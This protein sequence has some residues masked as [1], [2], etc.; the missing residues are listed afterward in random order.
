MHQGSRAL[1]TDLYELTMVQA[2]WR[3]GLTD[4][5]VFDLFVR[6]LSPR[7]NFLLA[8][9][10]DDV[11][12][13]LETLRFAPDELE[14]L[15][16]Q[17]Q[18]SRD[19]VEWLADFRFTGRVRAVREG[20]VI[21]A[22]EPILE[23]AAPLAEAQL[24]ETFLLNQINLQTTLASK[25]ARVALAARGRRV[26]DFG[27]RRMQGTDAALRGARAFYIGGIASTS[28]VQAGQ[29]YGIPI[30]G[31]MAH[32]YIQVHD[33]EDAAYRAF[34]ALYPSGVML[35][36]T[37]DTLE[38]VQ[39]VIELA[40]ELGDAFRPRGVRLDSGDLLEL[41]R[42]AREMLDSA[43]LQEIEVYASGD[44]DEDRIA[45]LV[46][47]GAPIDSFGVGSGLGAS[48]DA[49]YVDV[50]YKL[51]EYAGRARVKLSPG[52]SLLPGRKQIF[53]EEENGCFVRDVVGAEDEERGGSPLLEW[54]MR[55][56]RRFAAAQ[57]TLEEIRD[58]AGKQIASLPDRLR[59]LAPADPPYRVEAS[60]RLQA[61]QRESAES[62]RAAH[63][64][65]SAPALAGEVAR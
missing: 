40:R 27:M 63:A 55:D 49:P 13:Y 47:R 3:E 16:A 51:T 20:T 2:Y 28:N 39:R 31:T 18:F 56:G 36:D 61:L 21:F 58:Y 50:V 38:G 33:S 29:V 9:G 8:C 52:K 12:S 1:F 54:V 60:A 4:E 10:L 35:V 25:A 45:E 44:L 11:L 6:R 62:T 42:R 53:R 48:T 5:A 30:V 24:I 34:A 14:F 37:Y 15:A 57:R 22:N 43:G 32:S 65:R 41:S 26:V 46:E 7:R 64:S 59:A 17:S 19:F 23:V